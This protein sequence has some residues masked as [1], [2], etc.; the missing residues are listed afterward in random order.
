MSDEFSKCSWSFKH[1]IAVNQPEI[2][3]AARADKNNII[4]A[5]DIPFPLLKEWHKILAS[6]CDE[7]TSGENFPTGSGDEQASTAQTGR[8]FDYVDLL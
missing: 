6:S 1:Q 7:G 4:F 8:K 2:H 5:V 3:C